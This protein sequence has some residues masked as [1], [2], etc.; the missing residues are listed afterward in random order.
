MSENQ[1]QP[2]IYVSYVTFKNTLRGLAAHGAV[3][4]RIDKTLLTNLSGAAQALFLA[5]LNRLRL[6]ED[7]GTPTERLKEMAQADDDQWSEL[8]AALLKKHL[9]TE[10][11]ILK[12]GTPGELEAG[13]GDGF[14]ASVRSKAVRFL[15]QA[16]E[17]AKLPVAGQHKKKTGSSAPRTGKSK[18]A[19]RN[20]TASAGESTNH[21]DNTEQMHFPIYIPGKSSG[22][23]S[24]P[25]DIE[26][27][28]L[29]LIQAAIDS[30]K[31][32]AERQ[33]KL[34]GGTTNA[35]S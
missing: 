23:L 28:D 2:P 18:R 7:D 11:V 16:A 14:S 15:V 13:L 29:P 30:A 4:R 3:P 6:I 31:L 5:A 12:E 33:A 25:H 22:R 19:R 24:L 35:P 21:A 10:L 17:D 1:K 20:Q 9:G 26:P 32:F 8:L 34:K 27:E